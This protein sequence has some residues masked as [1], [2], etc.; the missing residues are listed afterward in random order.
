VI[1]AKIIVAGSLLR[2]CWVLAEALPGENHPHIWTGSL[3]KIRVVLRFLPIFSRT[4]HGLL[5]RL[6]IIMSAYLQKAARWVS[7]KFGVCHHKVDWV[8]DRADLMVI[9]IQWGFSSDPL[10][11][12]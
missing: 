3:Q 1:L 12:H 5:Y 6:V 8:L 4:T 10:P 9:I 7:E 2:P 11:V